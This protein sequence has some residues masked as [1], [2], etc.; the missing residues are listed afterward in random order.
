MSGVPR[1]EPFSLEHV[2][3]VTAAPSALDLDALPIGIG[4]S[5]YGSFDLPIEGRPPA[6]GIELVLRSIQRRPA[7]LAL[8]GSGTDGAFV[9]SG[10]GW[11][12][13]LVQD[14]TLF[15]PREGS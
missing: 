11:F 7:L 3:Q 15:R 6:M 4:D 12:R 8:V 14:H 1:G 10:K 5:T 9:F 13:A 2:A